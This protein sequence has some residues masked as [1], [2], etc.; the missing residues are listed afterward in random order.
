MEVQE[1]AEKILKISPA[2]RMVTICDLK[3]KI[4]F[5]ERRKNTT[6]KLSPAESKASLKM[7]ANQ[8]KKRKALSSKLGKC[9]YVVAEYDKVKRIVLPAG[10]NHLLYV[11]SSPAFDINKVI[12]KVRTFR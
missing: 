8:W 11:S 9:K 12:K 10:K 2:V 5:H 6:I 1:I 3:G 4:V 7:T